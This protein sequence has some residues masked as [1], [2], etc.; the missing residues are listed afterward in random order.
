MD[1]KKRIGTYV[2]QG[3]TGAYYKAYVPKKLPPISLE[4]EKL[5][6]ILNQAIEAIANL[7]ASVKF[8]QN[9]SLFIYMYVRKE[10]LLSSQIEGT[11]SSFADLMLFE[12][13]RPSKP[14]RS[15]E[16]KPQVAIEDVEEVSHYVEAIMYGL[17]RIKEDFSLSLR[18]IR[19]IH[20]VLLRG[21]RGKHKAPGLPEEALAKSGEFRKSQNWIGGSRPGNAL[22]VPPSPEYL[23]ECLSD[24][25]KFLY[26]EECPYHILIKAG[27]VHVQFETIHPFL[28]GNGRVGR[29]LIIFMLCESGFLADPIL[30]LSLYLKQNRRLYYDL[31][32]QVREQGTWETWL[33][34]FLQGVA[35]TAK[36]ASLTIEK[37]NRLFAK[38]MQAIESL[39][40]ARFS[41]EEV[42]EYLKKLPQVSVSLLAKELEMTEPTVRTA[43]ERLQQLNI[44]EEITGK[45]RDRTYVYKKYL[46]ILEQGTDP[47]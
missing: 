24:L 33:E 47:L 17:K 22:F 10:A 27:L 20:D 7:N 14:W 18:L 16:Q 34:F 21:G 29:L 6:P 4:V 31:L 19:E 12:H 40:K 32:Q 37:I 36:Q 38:D 30:Y 9:K 35:I 46:A 8:A 44:V 3:I 11:Q 39:G 23:K 15:R 43:L 25:E 1:I 26:D 13:A 41:A 5:Y 28:D 42:F 2:K 45:K